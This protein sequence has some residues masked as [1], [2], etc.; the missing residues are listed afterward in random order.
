MLI[1]E[2]VEIGHLW[3]HQKQNKTKTN[4]PVLAATVGSDHIGVLWVENI[5]TQ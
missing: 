3:K 1:N 5:L 2:V 4:Q